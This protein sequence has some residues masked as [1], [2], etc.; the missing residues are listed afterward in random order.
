MDRGELAKS[1]APALLLRLKVTRVHRGH[2]I[3]CSS[4][5]A[6]LA[7]TQPLDLARP[8]SLPDSFISGL[9]FSLLS[10]PLKCRKHSDSGNTQQLRVFDQPTFNKLIG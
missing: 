9:L 10:H 8:R 1:D 7:W 5:Y 4:C 3:A 2:R 6:C